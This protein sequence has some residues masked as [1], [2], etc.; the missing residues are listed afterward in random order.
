M[1]TGEIAL[2]REIEIESSDTL[3]TLYTKLEKLGTETLLDF[4]R[5]VNEGKLKLSPQ[6]GEFSNAPK[7][8]FFGSRHH[9]F[10]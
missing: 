3:G 8:Q 7:I 2:K 1:D 9:R 10:L 4:L 5:I 6:Q